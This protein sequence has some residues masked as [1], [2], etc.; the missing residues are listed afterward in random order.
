MAHSTLQI[1]S[2]DVSKVIKTRFKLGFVS[3]GLLCL[4][5]AYGQTVD[6]LATGDGYRD[7]EFGELLYNEASVATRLEILELLSKDTPSVLVFLHA[8]SM[9][10]GI[11]DVVQAAVQY[12]PEKARDFAES[13]IS[14]LPLLSDSQNYDYVGY[15]LDDLER[16]RDSE[17]YS[18]CL[19]YTSP[20]PRDR[21]KSRMPSSA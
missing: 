14:L 3:L 20:S 19:L 13:A 2:V 12:Q 5:S 1:L 7:T 6:Q 15:D 17:L 4:G 18:V 9:G 8:I 10:L 21:Q 16:D 11:E